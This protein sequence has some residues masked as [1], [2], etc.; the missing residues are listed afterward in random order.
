MKLPDRNYRPPKPAGGIEYPW[1]QAPHDGE[2]TRIADGVSWIRMPLPFALDHINLWILDDGHGWTVIDSGFGLPEI[3]R[4]W[5]TLL[6]GALAARKV[7][8][9]IVTH[10]H[11]D[12]F[13]QAGWLARRFA[14]PLWMPRTEWLTGTLL[15]ADEQSRISSRQAEFFRVHGLPEAQCE[16]MRMRGNVYRKVITPPPESYVRIKKGDVL[17][18]NG[19]EWRVI[20]GTGHAPEH[21]CLYCAERGLLI[22]GDQVLPGIS[23]NVTLHASEPDSDPLADFLRTMDELRDLPDDVLVLPSHG[24]PFRGLSSRLEWLAQHHAERLERVS[25]HCAR[26]RTAA[27]LLSVLFERE[28]DPHQLGFAM[29]ESLAHAYH[30]VKM[31]RLSRLD[32]DGVISFVRLAQ[33]SSTRP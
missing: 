7:T 22:S 3:S 6:D 29:G 13:G 10:F 32:G 5:E 1:S 15:F 31:G 17:D 18:I 20:T 33:A 26:P 23:P 12:H 4:L 28:M 14:V 9:L 2:V 19:L 24:F 8:R 16:R 25:E 11:P 27:D 21:A 30:L